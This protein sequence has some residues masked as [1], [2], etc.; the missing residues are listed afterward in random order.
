MEDVLAV[1]A[2]P[3]DPSRPVVCM[4]EKP[5]QLV[6]HA[7]D[8]VPAVPGRDRREDSEYVRC[9]TCS[10]FCWAEP[11]AGWRRAG[12]QPRRT[13]TGW[14][15][16]VQQLLTVDYP[17]A[18]TVVLVMDNPSTHGIASLYEASEPATAFALAQRPGIH[19]TTTCTSAGPA[20]CS[21]SLP[22]RGSGVRVSLAPPRS[23][24]Y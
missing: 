2:R 15:R 24:P 11:L 1:Y 3:R 4:D 7:R 23:S 17:G 8:P 9:G 12:A 22:S 13:R 18:Q 10:I 21:C 20:R 6:A 14:A 19:H 16:Q 5:C